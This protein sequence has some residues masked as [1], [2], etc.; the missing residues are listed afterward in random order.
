MPQKRDSYVD[1]KR[2]FRVPM[3]FHPTLDVLDLSEVELWFERVFGRPSISLATLID[4]GKLAPR[5]DYSKF[6]LINDVYFDTV[7]PKLHIVN[8]THRPLTGHEPHLRRFTWYI[9]GVGGTDAE[10]RA[11]DGMNEAYR[12]CKR[13][14]IRILDQFGEPVECNE[15][16]LG[17]WGSKRQIFFTMPE[18]TGLSYALCPPVAVPSFDPRTEPGWRVPEVSIKDPLGIECCSHHT[19]LMSQTAPALKLLCEVLGG[20]VVHEDRNEL[21]GANCVYVHLSG[22]T[23]ECAVPDSGTAAYADWKVRAPNDTYHAITWKVADLP[24]AKHHLETQG[25]R[26][27]AQLHDGFTTDPA[28]S[29]GIPWGFS[30][31][32]IPGDPRISSR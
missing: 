11:I 17:R 16:P 2:A 15:A 24:R 8:G 5:P 18:D 25:V 9:D 7:N 23:I 31:R 13:R 6:T 30:S 19:V 27:R 14:G 21:L 3:M 26:V 32:M 12:A 20:E 10:A 22:S 4:I 28:T 29:V 1:G